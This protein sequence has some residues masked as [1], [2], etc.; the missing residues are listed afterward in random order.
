MPI[1]VKFVQTTKIN[2]IFMVIFMA[3]LKKINL[4]ELAIL[5]TLLQKEIAFKRKRYP[6]V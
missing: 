6:L 2:L 3:Y 1:K 4:P 5:G